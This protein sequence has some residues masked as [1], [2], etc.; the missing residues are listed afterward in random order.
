M[1][2]PF[3]RRSP[4]AARA[5]S[6]ECAARALPRTARTTPDRGSGRNTPERSPRRKPARS[7]P[8]A[9]AKHAE[10]SAQVGKEGHLPAPVDD[11]LV[12]DLG[13]D[14]HAQVLEVLH[15]AQVDVR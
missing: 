4:A 8:G 2:G 1:R 13:A 14:L 6:R 9:K 7:R 15:G 3:R 5:V 12:Q 11:A 10:A